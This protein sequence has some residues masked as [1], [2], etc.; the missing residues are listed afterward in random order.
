M[1]FIG[2]A[3]VPITNN[4]SV[5]PRISGYSLASAQPGDVILYD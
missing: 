3:G 2:D 5:D 1:H 4:S